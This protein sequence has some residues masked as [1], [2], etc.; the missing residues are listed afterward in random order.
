MAGFDATHDIDLRKRPKP[1]SPHKPSQW[2]RRRKRPAWNNFQEK[3]D[4]PKLM[5]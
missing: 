1:A 2:L 3:L 4:K 5:V